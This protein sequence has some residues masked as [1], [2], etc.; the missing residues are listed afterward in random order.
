MFIL[1]VVIEPPRS[2]DSVRQST[3]T[4]EPFRPPLPVMRLGGPIV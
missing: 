2:H 3:G 1:A 4:Q